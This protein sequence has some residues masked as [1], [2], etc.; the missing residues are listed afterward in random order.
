MDKSEALDIAHQYA[1]NLIKTIKPA[2][3]ILYGSYANDT[4]NQNSDIDIAI[5]FDKFEGNFLETSSY[6][7]YLARQINSHIEPILLDTTND[8]SG[9]TEEILKNGL[10]IYGNNV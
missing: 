9:F 8:S 3:I 2:Q 7:W 1:N 6:L 5:I 10:F 4:F